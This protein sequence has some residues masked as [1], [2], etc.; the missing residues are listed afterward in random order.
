MIGIPCLQLFYQITSMV[1]QSLR[2]SL[3]AKSYE[4]REPQNLRTVLVK[5]NGNNET[6]FQVEMDKPRLT[7]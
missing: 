6:V 4:T 5:I 7:V 2:Y 3:T 1:T